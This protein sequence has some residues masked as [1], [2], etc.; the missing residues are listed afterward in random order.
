MA[1]KFIKKV[2][3][4][5]RPAEFYASWANLET[6]V[7]LE[8]GDLVAI[9]TDG[10][11]IKA[12]DSKRPVG[13][14]TESDTKKWGEA[15][16]FTGERDVMKLSKGTRVSLYKHFLM[17]GALAEG[18]LTSKQIGDPVYLGASGLTTTKPA[19]GFLVGQIER[20]TDGLVRFDLTL[21]HIPVASE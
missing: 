21:T 16:E 9:D 1:E 11:L 6:K 7:D 10:K 19:A 8:V 5:A 3:G 14:V 20:L 12:T 2:Y 18:E 17:S 4:C 13:I 15:Y